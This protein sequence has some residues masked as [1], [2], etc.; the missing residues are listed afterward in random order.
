MDDQLKRGGVIGKAS[1][2]ETETQKP[3]SIQRH[4]KSSKKKKRAL[5]IAIK[6]NG[7]GMASAMAAS[8]PAAYRHTQTRETLKMLYPEEKTREQPKRIRHT[9]SAASLSYVFKSDTI[10]RSLA[11]LV[12][13]GK[14]EPLEGPGPAFYKTIKA[15]K[16]ISQLFNPNNHWV[17]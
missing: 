1:D 4:V 10:R 3:D 12:G 8:I 15:Q 7:F 2:A 6:D 13:V 5:L 16:A 14:A 17:R 9:S 11:Q